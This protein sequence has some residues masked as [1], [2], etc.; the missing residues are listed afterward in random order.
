[1]ELEDEVDFGGVAEVLVE[2]LDEELDELHVGQ[3][4][5]VVVDTDDE[6]EPQILLVEDLV[7]H[8]LDEVGESGVSCNDQSVDV[9]LHLLF[10]SLSVRNVPLRKPVLSLTVLNQ[11]ESNHY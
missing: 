10:F 2:D 7:I 8:V 5:V 9:Q 3:F 4:V 1:M 11:N 6:E